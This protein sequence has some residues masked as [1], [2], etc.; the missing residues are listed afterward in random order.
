MRS[1]NPPDLSCF[2]PSSQAE[3]TFRALLR[4]LGTL[5]Q[6]MHPLFQQHDVTPAQ[7]AVLRLL[8]RA[9]KKSR[10]PLTVTDLGKL[11]L[12]RPPSVT[13]V[14]DG[15]VERGLVSRRPC[16]VDGRVREMALTTK[17]RKLYAALACEHEKRVRQIMKPLSAQEAVCL[18]GLLEKL[19]D[20]SA[21]DELPKM[22]ANRR[23][24]E[25]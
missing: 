8:S 21:M 7:W 3:R 11:L 19:A 16:E 1:A 22:P 12:V 17:G 5:R 25:D 18:Q 15:L 2:E 13:G 10:P 23:T 9:A 14:V 4:A 20:A 24:S 6:I